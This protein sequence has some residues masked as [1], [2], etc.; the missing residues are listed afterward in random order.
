MAIIDYDNRI[1]FDLPTDYIFERS[2]DRKGQELVKIMTGEDG[3]GDYDFYCFIDIIKYDSK[4]P[5]SLK[6]LEFA[7][8]T[9]SSKLICISSSP[10][11]YIKATRSSYSVFGNVYNTFEL[12]GQITI[13]NGMVLELSNRSMDNDEGF[14]DEA[15]AIQR[16]YKVLTSVCVDGKKLQFD[17]SSSKDLE[18]KLK[19]NA[20][21]EIKDVTPNIQVNISFGNDTETY[22]ISSNVPENDFNTSMPFSEQEVLEK[23]PACG[24]WL[25]LGQITA[26]CKNTE[27]FTE[28]D[29]E[30]INEGLTTH[31]FLISAILQRD[32]ALYELA[33]ESKKVA[34]SFMLGVLIDNGNKA[35]SIFEKAM[36][37][38][39]P[40]NFEKAFILI[41]LFF[42][43]PY[44]PA[45]SL[46]FE[47][48]QEIML[49][50][51][52]F[53][54]SMQVILSM[55]GFHF[56]LPSYCKADIVSVHR[57]DKQENGGLQIVPEQNI[58]V[59]QLYKDQCDIKDG[60]FKGCL[61]KQKNIRLPEGIKE[62][63]DNAFL[64]N[65]A[66]ECVI[67]PEGV[68]RIG[69]SFRGCDNLTFINL[70]NSLEY[71]GKWAFLDCKK[72]RAI[73]IPSGVKTIETDSIKNC[74]SLAYILIPSSVTNMGINLYESDNCIMQVERG[75]E[76]ER[77][78]KTL[79]KSRDRIVYERPEGAVA[80][81]DYE[82]IDTR[83]AAENVDEAFVVTKDDPDAEVKG[84]QL[85]RYNNKE[86]VS[87]KISGKFKTVGTYAFL[88]AEK[89][90]SL[91]IEEG[92]EEIKD[93][94]FSGCKNLKKISFPSTM[95]KI[96]KDAFGFCESLEEIR[97]P[98]GVIQ[99]G[100]GAF[101][102][103][104][105]LKTVYLPKSLEK[106]VGGGWLI[107]RDAEFFVPKGSYAADYVTKKYKFSKINTI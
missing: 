60:V 88:G 82:L 56:D 57:I 11:V 31:E 65:H 87:I 96:G 55:E 85:V 71:I 86:V 75:S 45:A 41:S 107:A 39:I 23:G 18:A 74:T 95:R 106:I 22:N 62:I 4:S 27:Y 17:M 100:N 51:R 16:F 63:A 47:R 49:D 79:Y 43:I 8:I 14:I 30:I 46:P 105:K 42:D 36:S 50:C 52:G 25:M 35:I 97:I 29:I 10:K 94:A 77:F 89:L 19:S 103:C 24:I 15:T 33:L 76:A 99:I 21:K 7:E 81:P 34:A 61:C 101:N 72:L 98:E 67:V 80:F 40:S 54:N 53:V 3:E 68:K 69:S 37:M 93:L 84:D 59:V 83:K 6:I 48:K 66:L 78:V 20:E 32:P 91:I 28:E 9:D 38:K 44:A 64:L 2:V 102:F 1:S 13:S 26:L 73:E 5:D 92:V 58:Q 12:T 90:E 104:R 70:P